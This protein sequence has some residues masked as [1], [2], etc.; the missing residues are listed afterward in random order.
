MI[1]AAHIILYSTNAEAD[2]VFIRDVLG[3]AGVDAGDGWLVFK[4]PPA[5]IAVHPTD[6]LDKHEFYLMCD[7]IEKTITELTAKG[8]T[9]SEPISEQRWGRLISI[10][11]PSGADLSIYQPRH[12]TA[13]DLEG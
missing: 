10:K 12:P 8:I 11:L 3:L 13:Y 4:L 7:D 2:R 9:I 1:N 6:G 5:E